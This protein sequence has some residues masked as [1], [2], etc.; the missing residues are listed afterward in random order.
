MSG[1]HNFFRETHRCF[2]QAGLLSPVLWLCCLILIAQGCANT[3]WKFPKVAQKE[4]PAAFGPEPSLTDIV[5]HLNH[6]IETVDSWRATNVS[7]SATGVPVPLP[8]KVAV[9]KPNNLRIMVNSPTGS[10]E[11]DLGSNNQE[12]WAW[13]NQMEPKCIMTCSHTNVGALQQQYQVPLKMEWVQQILGM[14]MYDAGRLQMERMSSEP[15]LVYLVEHDIDGRGAPV[16]KVAVFDLKLGHVVAHQIFDKEE[17]LMAFAELSDYQK[18]AQGN[19]LPHKIRMQLVAQ[20]MGLTL[21]LKHIDINPE[22]MAGDMW[23]VP[24]IAGSPIQDIG[25]A[26]QMQNQ[27]T[28]QYSSAQAQPVSGPWD[29]QLNT[30]QQIQPVNNQQTINPTTADNG[31]RMVTEYNTTP[32]GYLE[33]N[34][35]WI[36]S[37]GSSALVNQ[38]SGQA[39]IQQQQQSTNPWNQQ[40]SPQAGSANVPKTAN[41][42][43]NPAYEWTTQKMPMNSQNM[44][45]Q[46]MDNFQTSNV[47]A[48]NVSMPQAN[49]PV[50]QVSGT[51][52]LP[53][54][55]YSAEASSPSSDPHPQEQ[56]LWRWLYR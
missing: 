24:K 1:L 5:A 40:Y 38:S 21:H 45:P 32:N 8:G 46:A 22:G 56:G 30:Q 42:P 17:T 50:Q 47:P 48:R 53:P 43:A 12:L 27:Q 41:A 34:T 2:K 26:F 25:L 35:R 28:P 23:N 11:V 49:N 15:N 54:A 9:Q 52:T 3:S 19:E 13:I 55:G 51:A 44:N 31:P 16:K 6:Q 29:Q 7:V 4:K 39:H 37:D 36:N 10:P 18:D 14:R 33:K 20:R